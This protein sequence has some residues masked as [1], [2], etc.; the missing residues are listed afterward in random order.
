MSTEISIFEMLKAPFDPKE[1]KWRIGA[2]TKDKSKGIPLAY[3]DAR[4]VMKRLDDVVGPENWQSDYNETAKRILCEL[5]VRVDGEWIAKVD[6]AGDT[7]IE[8]E[9]GGI[10]DALKRAAVNFG[11]GRYL[12]YLPTEW[13]EL[14]QYGKF[15]P[16]SLPKW[17][18]P[19]PFQITNRHH[20]YLL[21]VSRKF[22]TIGDVKAAIA[23]DDMQAAHA[24]YSDFSQEEKTALWMAPS[25]GGIFTTKEVE[26]IKSNFTEVKECIQ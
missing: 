11:V 1:I 22:D 17:A 9:K 4:N 6:G 19:K 7:D 16:P 20:A 23:N 2:R 13:V 26:I 5:K 12:Y 25:N 3:I 10:S 24:A 15:K 8:G 21:E 14:D 18:T